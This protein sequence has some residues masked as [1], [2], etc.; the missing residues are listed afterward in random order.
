MCC[1]IINIL[2]GKHV[3]LWEISLY[4]DLKTDKYSFIT[5]YHSNIK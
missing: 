5:K 1:Y 2:H 3:M 4:V